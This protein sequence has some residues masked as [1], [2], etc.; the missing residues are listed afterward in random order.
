MTRLTRYGWASLAGAITVLLAACVGSPAPRAVHDAPRAEVAPTFHYPKAP[1]GDVVDDYH[2]TKVP[3]PYRAFE[4]MAAA[5]TRD[6]VTA[7][8]ALAQP[9]LESLPQRAWLGNRLK[10]LWT[11]ERFGTPQREA[12]KYFY[13]RNDGTQDQSVLYVADS[14]NAT[15]RV[16]VDPNVTRE[17]ATIALSQW[18]PSPNGEYVAYALSD[19]GT[20][21]NLWHF[22]R[23]ADGKDLPVLLKYSKFWPVSWAR[24][25][26]GVYYSRYPMKPNQAADDARGDD[27]GRPDVYFHKLDSPQS[28][29]ELVFKVTDHPSRVPSAQVTEDGRWLVIGLFD[30]YEANGIYVQDL[31]KRDS[32]P[33]PLLMAWDAI[34]TF[35]GNQ[36]DQLYFHTTNGAPRGRVIAVRANQPS[37]ADWRTVVAQAKDSIDSVSYVGGRIVV[38]YTRDARSVVQLFDASTGAAAGEVKLPGLGTAGGFQGGGD[39]PETFFSYS[40]YLSPTRVM[41][42]DVATNTVSVFRAP[43]VP[44]DFTPFVTEQVFYT[45]RDGTRVPMFI[46][47]RKDA[48]RDG[49]RPVMLYGY[50]GFNV[51]M[52]PSFSPAIQSWLEL[53]GI[54]AVANLRGGG[55]YGEEWHQAGTRLRKQNVF[56]DFIAA[57]EYLIREKFTNPKRLA[58]LGRSNGGL[59]VGAALTQRPEL[60]G[61][62]LPGVGVM[63]M[64]RYHVASANA[65]QWS[66]DLGISED[67]AEFKALRA[68]SPV[69]NVKPGACY[70]PTLVTT[71]DRDDRVVP[72]HSY[73]FAAELQSAQSCPNPVMIRIETRAGH[74]AGKPVWMQIE[75]IADQFGFVANALGMPA[76][77]G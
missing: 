22:R 31:R 51:T 29:D 69:H 32:K 62:A 39:D 59:L 21:W 23:V 57:A 15:P 50:G 3:D 33:Q 9:F 26:S 65:R 61:A 27:S 76:P 46:T 45:S 71:A 49:N 44:V 14:L 38:E 66:S 70:P 60:F 4:D 24:D 17:D 5:A 40:D 12:G 48:P 75:D 6:W 72:W 10:Q 34:Y 11:Y 58:I 54:Y 35:V 13:L 56:D 42:L 19:G 53:G 1:R 36:G 8:N 37:V 28:A 7:E 74:G 67:P 68:Y 41:R 77:T 47:R 63:D 64:L 2:G 18:S 52:S 25:S 16:L 43:N 20:D 30:G 73:K 55:E